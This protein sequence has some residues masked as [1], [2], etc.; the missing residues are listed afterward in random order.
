MD[1]KKLNE[2]ESLELI[3][4]MIRNARTNLRAR[5]NC[6]TILA[7]G[8]TVVSISLLMWIMKKYELFLYSSFLWL[9]IPA[10]GYFA[11]RYFSSED[12]TPIKS[13]LDKIIDYISILFISVGSTVGLSAILV[14]FPVLFIEGIIFN[15]LIIIIGLIISHCLIIIPDIVSQILVFA[16]IPVFSII[17]PGHLFK[18]SISKNV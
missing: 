17:I 10:I 7:W 12:T 1:N 15:I 18:N 2:A 16:T 5:I 3:S 11:M 4:L 6:N 14:Y 8:Y 9:L 13:Y